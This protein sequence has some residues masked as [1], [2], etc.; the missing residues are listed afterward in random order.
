[1]I[2]IFVSFAGVLFSI[3]SV[4]ATARDNRFYL[5]CAL[6][7]M[8]FH[9][10]CFYI[11]VYVVKYWYSPA[12]MLILFTVWNNII[13]FLLIGV[14][15]ESFDLFISLCIC[16]CVSSMVFSLFELH[17][18]VNK[19]ENIEMVEVKLPRITYLEVW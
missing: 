13:M 1:M 2:G 8:V 15:F 17:H 11:S 7:S 18:N 12:V 14:I 3:I 5:F 6:G 4:F 16:M 10:F 19:E 9:S